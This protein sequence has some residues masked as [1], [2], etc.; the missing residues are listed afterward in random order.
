MLGR[1]ALIMPASRSAASVAEAVATR[2]AGEAGLADGASMQLVDIVRQLVDFS[3]ERSYEG[4]ACGDIELHLEL[5]PHGVGIDLHDWG[6]PMRRSGGPDGPLPADLEPIARI[7]RDVRL[8]NLADDGKRISVHLVAEH[9]V[10]IVDGDADGAADSD[11]GSRAR[12]RDDV[13]I[14]DAAPADAEAVAQ[15]LW[16]GY[17]L[18][19]RHRDFYRPTWIEQ[20][21]RSGRVLSTVACAQ[22]TVI[23]HHAVIVTAPNEAAA[24]GV[25]LID[26]AW[27]GLGLFDPMFDHTLERA[28]AAG[29]PAMFGRAT[30]AHPYSQRTELKHGYRESALMLGESPPAM[31]QAQ[32]DADGTPQRRGANLISSRSLSEGPD[33]AL[34]LP[35][36]YAAE[37]RTLAEHVGVVVRAP[38][39]SVQPLNGPAEFAGDD[40]DDTVYLRISGDT[41]GGRRALQRALRSE[42][43]RR[44]AVL[45]ADVDLAVPGDDVVEALW[46]Q[47]FFLSGFIHAGLGG[48]DWLRLQCL[49]APAEVESLAL[50]G[51]RGQWLLDRIL[52][53]RR[54]VV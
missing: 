28:R 16:H 17:V 19:Y 53:D 5:D 39:P 12:A 25:A 8:I 33:R 35:D 32:L 22:A 49:Q 11:R 44:S 30:C 18:S 50:A 54:D 4:R 13:E 29:L 20:A 9:A 27:R 23:G 38:D 52:K 45:Y 47:G 34:A 36:R 26:R 24:S 37:L 48:R 1:V 46:A 51:A 42:V 7:A 15:L 41:W 3:V 2:V 6:A 21:I 43:A 31:A 10:P 40:E 14:R